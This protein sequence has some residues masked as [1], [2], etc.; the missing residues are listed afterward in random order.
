MLPEVMPPPEKKTPVDPLNLWAEHYDQ[1]LALM[2]QNNPDKKVPQSAKQNVPD[3]TNMS[4][5]EWKPEVAPTPDVVYDP[6]TNQTSKPAEVTQAQGSLL[7]KINDGEYKT[8]YGYTIFRKADGNVYYRDDNGE[9]FRPGD[10][11]ENDEIIAAFEKANPLKPL[12]VPKGR[13]GALYTPVKIGDKE[14]H[15]RY[16]DG[17]LISY[18][19]ARGPVVLNGSSIMSADPKIK[20]MYAAGLKEDDKKYGYEGTN[21]EDYTADHVD[22]TKYQTNP[23]YAK[24]LIG[25]TLGNPMTWEE[26]YNAMVDHVYENVF[27][28]QV[29]EQIKLNE[30]L[31]AEA[32]NTTSGVQ[33]PNPTPGVLKSGQSI[34]NTTSEK[35]ANTLQEKKLSYFQARQNA[36]MQVMADFAANNMGKEQ[37]GE[38]G[39]EVAADVMKKWNTDTFLNT[40]N[41]VAQ[42]DLNPQEKKALLNQLNQKF[43]PN[44]IRQEFMMNGGKSPDPEAWNKFVD[45][46]LGP[47]AK[48]M[49]YDPEDLRMKVRGTDVGSSVPDA[50][51]MNRHFSNEGY[52]S[53]SNSKQLQNATSKNPGVAGAWNGYTGTHAL[54]K[55]A[56]DDISTA[57]VNPREQQGLIIGLL[58]RVT[59]NK[60]DPVMASTKI[61]MAIRQN[62]MSQ[63]EAEREQRAKTIMTNVAINAYNSAKKLMDEGKMTTTEGQTVIQGMLGPDFKLSTADPKNAAIM[64]K[65]PVTQDYEVVTADHLG[66]TINDLY[67]TTAN[68][69]HNTGAVI[70]RAAQMF[71]KTGDIDDGFIQSG[72]HLILK[73]LAAEFK[74]VVKNTPEMKQIGSKI[75]AGALTNYG[76]DR[77]LLQQQAEE[78]AAQAALGQMS[79]VSMV[80]P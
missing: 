64:H 66:Q 28:P 70:A 57:R 73:P 36:E 24:K 35:E 15:L 2:D 46:K 4:A 60:V 41:G 72:G 3:G 8:P 55:T 32:N 59:D 67:R 34:S 22:W 7:K 6:K 43:K 29:D 18:D 49:G 79:K 12:A 78:A 48:L 50:F 19:P 61:G 54:L 20:E 45:D 23:D 69:S 56:L 53:F 16:S 1:N 47:I 17:N 63:P 39:K 52:R 40:L 37:L 77:V 76:G 25:Q 44:V 5:T 75:S 11:P 33:D 51:V 74:E 26:N 27:K 21:W 14:Q 42:S 13:D 71:A 68:G 30:R 31:V 62:W 9:E 65:N 58:G 80:R 10:T 38:K